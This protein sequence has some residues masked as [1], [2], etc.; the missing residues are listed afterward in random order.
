MMGSNNIN[1]TGNLN[2]NTMIGNRANNE[3]SGLDGNDILIGNKGIDTI[4][5]GNGA[6]RFK[7][8][9]INDSSRIKENADLIVDFS[10]SEGDVLDL[11]MIDANVNATG[12]QS[13]V[14]RTLSGRLLLFPPAGTML[15]NAEDKYISLYNDNVP[16]V[17]MIIKF[18]DKMPLTSNINR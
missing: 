4:S 1:G 7:F 10:S 5:G 3:L 12:D 18:G 15:F 8:N 13:F 14:R 16:G 9:R 17:D 6:D 2:D 11:S